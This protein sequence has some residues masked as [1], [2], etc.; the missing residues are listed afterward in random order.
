MESEGSGNNLKTI[1]TIDDP[2]AYNQ[3]PTKHTM[4]S[5]HQTGRLQ[6]HR[7]PRPPKIVA[8]ASS[9]LILI[10][11]PIT[12]MTISSRM[13]SSPDEEFVDDKKTEEVQVNCIPETRFCTFFHQF[14]LNDQR[15]C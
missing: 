1:S 3:M 10:Q 2:S 9:D 15:L 14:T 7:T 6:E 12:Q 13:D 4:I 11:I 5:I 8:S